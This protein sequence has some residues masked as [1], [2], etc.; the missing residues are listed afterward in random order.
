[1][2][3]GALQVGSDEVVRFIAQ[4]A[5]EVIEG[6]S[7]SPLAQ[8]QPQPSTEALCAREVPVSAGRAQADRLL[9]RYLLFIPV[10]SLIR[11]KSKAQGFVPFRLLIRHASIVS[12]F[13]ARPPSP[14]CIISAGASAGAEPVPDEDG[15]GFWVDLV[16][17]CRRGKEYQ[18]NVRP[19]APRPAASARTDTETE[20]LCAR[21]NTHQSAN[22]SQTGA[23]LFNIVRSHPTAVTLRALSSEWHVSVCALCSGCRSFGM[24]GFPAFICRLSV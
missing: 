6:S 3:F 19:E 10:S 5:L 2:G 12:Y 24:T 16:G 14:I 23:V 1:M 17:G 4:K 11:C 9:E 8:P 18:T 21:V 15:L 7:S 22:S 13:A 20:A